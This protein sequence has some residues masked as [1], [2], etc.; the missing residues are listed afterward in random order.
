MGIKL[1]INFL[2]WFTIYSHAFTSLSNTTYRTDST[3]KVVY[4]LIPMFNEGFIG[5]IRT[6]YLLLEA[7]NLSGFCLV[8]FTFLTEFWS[9]Y[10]VFIFVYLI[11]LNW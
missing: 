3:G 9:P 1:L 7:G 4:S 2:I 10:A 8:G 6:L 5:P 11:N